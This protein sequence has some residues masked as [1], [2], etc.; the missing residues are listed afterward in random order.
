[1]VVSISG[2]VFGWGRNTFGQLGVGHDRDTGEPTELATLR[3]QRVTYI[4]CGEKHTA[5]LTEVSGSRHNM[6]KYSQYSIN[7]TLYRVLGT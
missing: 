2:T 5:A 6:L 3:T 7:T 4:S 1:M